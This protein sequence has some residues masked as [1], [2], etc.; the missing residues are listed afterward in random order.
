[1]NNQRRRR[2]RP[3]VVCVVKESRRSLEKILV[4]KLMDQ[5]SLSLVW[6]CAARM[7]RRCKLQQQRK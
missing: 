5:L 4:D 7:A 1:M 6:S 3:V 2:R